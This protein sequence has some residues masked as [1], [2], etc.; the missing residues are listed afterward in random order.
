MDLV[1]LGYIDPTGGLPP[2]MWGMMFAGLV[3]FISV[4]WA[5]IKFY[6]G[7]CYNWLR[8]RKYFL[9]LPLVA[10]G[11]YFMPLFSKSSLKSESKKKLLILALDGL[12]PRLLEKYMEEGRLPNFKRLAETGIYHPLETTTPPQSP[13]AWASFITGLPPSGHGIFDFIKR[14]P[15]T[16]LPD[17]TIADRKALSRPWKGK[18]FWERDGLKNVPITLIRLPLAFPPPKLNGRVLAGMG[19]WD[20]RGTEGT[21]FY[22]STKAPP[23]DARGMVFQLKVESGVYS[24]EIP[25]PYRAGQE[26]TIREPFQLVRDGEKFRLTIQGN[27]FVLKPRRWSDWISIKFKLGPLQSI[28]TVTKV[29]L[30]TSG[31]DVSLYISPLNLDPSNSPYA[32]S[33]PKNYAGELKDRL[34]MY[35]TRGMPF[36]TQAVNDGVMSDEAFLAQWDDI[37]QQREKMLSFELSRFKDGILFAY[38]EGPDL[39]QHMYFRGIDPEHPLYAESAE[40]RDVIPDAYKQMDELVGRSMATLAKEDALIVI[41]DHG[42]ASFRHAVH[43]NAIL[44][45]LGFLVLKDGHKTSPEFFKFAD[46]EKTVAYAYGFNALYLNIEGREGQGSLAPSEVQT[47]TQAIKMAL[48]EYIDPQTG[49]NPMKTVYIIELESDSDWNVASP[50]LIIG[51]R[52][53][54]RGSWETALGRVPD[55]TLS[56]NRKKWSGD[57]CI[58]P[59]EVPGIFLSN[60]AHWDS[61]S[62]QAVGQTISQ[63][64]ANK[65]D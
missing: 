31:E 49:L 36:D 61:L 14:D 5:F 50:N 33:Y 39:I 7:Q 45:D 11:V 52:R 10:I 30:E 29:W 59:T 46:W 47:L 64:F 19:V 57:H 62:L 65:S 17:L 40:F 23:V 16:Y 21:Y 26:D 53:T 56:P 48:E 34:G 3:G 32:L 58:D 27:E 51:Y 43:L 12:D 55:T 41:S 6:G 37:H 13:V 63:L 15:A 18:P 8:V 38:F 28:N 22:Y 60:S 54:F 4:I 42:F 9:L 25:G 2:S 44:R 1:I 24:G 20:A 35:H